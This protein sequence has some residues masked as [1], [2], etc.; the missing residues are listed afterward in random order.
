MPGVTPSF[1]KSAPMMVE[2]FDSVRIGIA[3]PT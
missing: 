3:V 2:S 1:T